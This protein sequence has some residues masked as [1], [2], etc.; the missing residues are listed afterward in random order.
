MPAVAATNPPVLIGAG[1]RSDAADAGRLGRRDAAQPRAAGGG[2]AVRPARGGL[3]GPDRPGHRPRAGHRP[4][5]VVRPPARCRGSDRR[6][7]EPLP[8]VRRQHPGDDGAVRR[9]AERGRPHSTSSRR[10]RWPPRCRRSGSWA[11]RTTRHAWRPRRGCRTCSPTTSPV[12]ARPR[13]SSC[14]G[15]RSGRLRAGGAAHVPDGQRRGGAHGRGGRAAGAAQP[16]D[17]GRAPHRAAAGAQLLVEEAEKVELPEAHRSLVAG[18][19]PAGWSAT[20]EGARAQL[21]DLAA[22][23]GVD[24]VMV[25]PVAGAHVGT[26]PDRSPA[27]EETLA[28]LAGSTPCEFVIPG[29]LTRLTGRPNM[30]SVSRR[31]TAARTRTSRLLQGLD[32]SA[33]R[34]ARAAT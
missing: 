11:P 20:P 27:R 22:T 13:R 12:A 34:G 18:C 16:A 8:G 30:G 25:H 1:G 29:T 23:Y 15:R 6:G 19:G 2:R 14:T 24:E 3:P 31:L 9:R 33:G 17:D 5:D 4:G 26:E 7:G 28:L 10:R 21:A 32:A